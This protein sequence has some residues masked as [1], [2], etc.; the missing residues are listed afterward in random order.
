MPMRSGG[1]RD[2]PI[3]FSAP[4]IQALLAGRKTQTRRRAWQKANVV[5]SRTV[6]GVPTGLVVPPELGG[7]PTR[8]PSRW[9]SLEPGD[10]LWVKEVW[11]LSGEWAQA[12]NAWLAKRL[13]DLR[14]ITRDN[15]LYRAS[16]NDYDVAV[17]A[18]RHVR[19]MPRWASRLTLVVTQ[20]RVQRL[21]E[22]TPEDCDA[23][24]FAGDFPH[25]VLP[26]LFPDA[27]EAGGLSL[28]DCFG[29][30]WDSLHGAGAWAGNPEVVALSF[31][32]H[33]VNIDAHQQE[34]GHADKQ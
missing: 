9:R 10:R 30:L 17:Q 24:V 15:R 1:A 19:H 3:E 2:V 25:Q 29:R 31:T 28:P 11:A 4:M 23:E 8:L 16:A 33:P 21:Q 27:D 18:W 13:D 6:D 20:V 14:D 26:H 7:E 34:T 22:I 5:T 12:T 32:V